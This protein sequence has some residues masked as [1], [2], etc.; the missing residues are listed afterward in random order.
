VSGARAGGALRGWGLAGPVVVVVFVLFA[1]PTVLVLRY[2]VQA[3]DGTFSLTWFGKFLADPFYRK[4]LY[5]TL[6]LALIATAVCVILGL[7]YAYVLATRPKFRAFHLFALLSPLLINGVVRIFGLQT[8]LSS[9]NRGLQNIG[10][11][12]QPLPLLYS[13]LG[14][15]IGLVFVM[16][17]FMVIAIY[18]SV[19][20][21]DVSL[22]EAA[23]TLGATRL[24]EFRDVV[25]P[26]AMPGVIAGSILTFT[27]AAGS[28]FVP[29][30]MGG[31]NVV[32]MPTLVFNS[33]SQLDQ[34]SFGAAVAVLLVVIVLPLLVVTSRRAFAG[35]GDQT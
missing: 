1:V 14:I 11:I 22:N 2:S 25:V 20:K 34:W 35:G 33:V 30:M 32:T 5:D 15:V 19:S 17:P 21:I 10:V 6:S 12:G 23:R 3:G 16:L 28:Y 13:R 29:A 26:L 4:V 8:L 31:N 7:P 24:R 18:A 9:I 27:G